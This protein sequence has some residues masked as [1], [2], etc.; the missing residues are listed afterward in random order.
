MTRG[1][2]PYCRHGGGFGRW[3][4]EDNQPLPARAYVNRLAKTEP[5]HAQP[6]PRS[7]SVIKRSWLGL[8]GAILSQVTLSRDASEYLKKTG[9]GI[10]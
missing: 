9:K 3:R 1:A 2:L 10:S 6:K 8:L 7:E 4:T 5:T